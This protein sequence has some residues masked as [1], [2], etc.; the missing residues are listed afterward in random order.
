MPALFALR[1]GE[2][3]AYHGVEHK[4][5]GAYEDGDEDARDA[6]KEHER[7]GSHLVAPMLVSNLAGTLLL[8]R[9]TSTRPGRERRRRARLLRGRGRGVR[10]VR[11]NTAARRARSAPGLRDP[12]A[13]RDARAGRAPAR[14]RPRRA[15]GDPARR[16]GRRGLARPVQPQHPAQPGADERALARVAPGRRE[17]PE[18]VVEDAP[19]ARRA[20]PDERAA[21]RAPAREHTG[22][23]PHAGLVDEEL[24]RQREARRDPA[25]RRMRRTRTRST[26]PA[27][28]WW[29]KRPPSSASQPGQS[30]NIPLAEWK[31]ASPPP[32]RTNR[33]SAARS[34]GS[35]PLLLANT[36]ASAERS[37]AAVRPAPRTSRTSISGSSA[38][39]AARAAGIDA[40]T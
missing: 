24:L 38:R 23:P 21:R 10:V 13:G 20:D 32:R 6:T 11:A 30:S 5:I 17:V 12:A 8:R 4:A 9:A 25:R 35:S 22:A 18:R 37:A 31:P 29:S 27:A 33:R 3:A 16:A 40:W 14:G 15:G 1:G 7:C 39:I 2:L 19:A 34:T 36:T 26:A 28:P